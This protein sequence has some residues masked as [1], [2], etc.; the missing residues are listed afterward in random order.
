MTIGKSRIP[1]LPGVRTEFGKCICILIITNAYYR[2]K[3]GTLVFLV[4]LFPCQKEFGGVSSFSVEN[5]RL[6]FGLSKVSETSLFTNP[7]D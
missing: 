2:A 3:Q 4:V 6:F 7:L 1:N 5:S